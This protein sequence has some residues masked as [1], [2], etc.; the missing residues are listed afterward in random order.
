MVKQLLHKIAKTF[1]KIELV[2]VEHKYGVVRRSRL[3][4]FN[5]E[6]LDLGIV[7]DGYNGVRNGPQWT[8]PLQL[9]ANWW[10]SQ[11]HVKKYCLDEDMNRVYKALQ[12][13]DKY[14]PS[15]KP[16]SPKVHVIKDPKIELAQFRI[17]NGKGKE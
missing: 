17:I 13:C 2:R 3:N 1:Y 15:N 4:P 7:D 6:Y 5:I 12:E 10:K 8:R 16:K 11:E 14:I 9:K